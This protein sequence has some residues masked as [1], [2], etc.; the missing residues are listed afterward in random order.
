MEPE[1]GAFG[2][3]MSKLPYVRNDALRIASEVFT[4]ATMETRFDYGG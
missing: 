1:F 2:I 3:S 4:Q